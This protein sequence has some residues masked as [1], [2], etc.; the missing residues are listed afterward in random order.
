MS[1]GHIVRSIGQTLVLE[2][3][4][5]SLPAS[6]VKMKVMHAMD[7][8]GIAY[9]PE[10]WARAVAFL[11]T[12]GHLV[13]DGDTYTLRSPYPADEMARLEDIP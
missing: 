11:A 12:R 2:H 10:D 1:M 7:A 9:T 8:A 6:Q 13:T 4:H 3:P 5:R